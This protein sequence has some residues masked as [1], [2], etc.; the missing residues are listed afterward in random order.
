MEDTR[1]RVRNAD[2]L[3]TPALLYYKDSMIQNTQNAIR[4][5]GDANRLWPHVKSH[6]IREIVLLQRSMGIHRF[7]CATIKELEMVASCGAEHILLAYPLVGPNTGRFL[8]VAAA[9]PESCF[10]AIGDDFKQ[11]EDLSDAAIE[12][13]RQ[14]QTLL[15]VNMGM[16]RTGVPLEHAET[17]YKQC[18]AL[19]GIQMA[20]M[21]CYD[22][23]C[24]DPDMEKRKQ[25]AQS[26]IEA[27]RRIRAELIRQG[28]S[29]K[30]LVMGGTPS[31]PVH[32]AY[33][34]VYLSPGTIF[35]G[36]YRYASDFTELQMVP[37]VAV[38][39]R[40]ISH[41]A[42]GLFTLD[43]GSKGIST[44]VAGRGCLLGVEGAEA[45]FQ[46]EEHWV[47][48]MPADKPLPA[49]GEVLYVIPMHVCTTNALYDS[50]YVVEG[51]EVVGSWAISARGRVLRQAL[52]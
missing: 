23:H 22:G 3:L 26:S 24:N 13:G 49:I 27:V 42:E 14:V 44:D 29:C 19:P 4:L 2:R 47:Y 7:K 40:V 39:T 18:A 46:S 21:H 31:F 10:Y 37:A 12:A 52:I 41:P 36:D 9:Y 43:L 17:L 50:V 32:A 45:L 48:R 20:G 5:A 11:L 25:K 30:L 8:E 35:L 16:N 33:D 28:H 34:D 51:N 1:Y 38:M 15:D 6:K